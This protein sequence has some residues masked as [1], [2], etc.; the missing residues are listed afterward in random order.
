MYAGRLRKRRPK[1]IDEQFKI[2]RKENLKYRRLAL[3]I[4]FMQQFQ[5]YLANYYIVSIR[6]TL[7]Q[8]IHPEQFC[9]WVYVCGVL[10][11]KATA[12]REFFENDG[13]HAMITRTTEFLGF[14]EWFRV[15][16]N[17]ED[18]AVCMRNM[19]YLGFGEWFRFHG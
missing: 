9:L 16:E 18:H 1:S 13:D 10:E 8:M 11:N 17:D 6:K 2:S 14:G 7:R 19:E 3:D 5:A 15:H 4:L 12:T